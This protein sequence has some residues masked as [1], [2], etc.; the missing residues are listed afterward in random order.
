MQHVPSSSNAQRQRKVK[1]VT[2]SVTVPEGTESM[3]YGYVGF[4]WSSRGGSSG[5]TPKQPKPKSPTNLVKEVEELTRAARITQNPNTRK[6]LVHRVEKLLAELSDSSDD[7]YIVEAAATS[8]NKME[9]EENSQLANTIASAELKAQKAKAKIS[10]NSIKY[11]LPI[12]LE[13]DYITHH[14]RPVYQAKT[15]E[16]MASSSDQFYDA[17][18][19]AYDSSSISDAPN[20]YYTNSNIF[21]SEYPLVHCVS[22]D[23]K[24]SKGIARMVVQKYG[25]PSGVEQ[26][27]NPGDIFIQEATDR[28]IFHVVTKELFYQ[29]PTARTF[30]S[31]MLSLKQAL[32]NEGITHISMPCIGSGL[33]KMTW[34]DTLQIIKRVFYNSGITIAI[35][36]GNNSRQ[37]VQIAEKPK[38]IPNIHPRT[39]HHISERFTSTDAQGNKHTRVQSTYKHLGQR[40]PTSGGTTENIPALALEL[41]K[42]WQGIPKPP[43][44]LSILDKHYASLNCNDCSILYRCPKHSP[45]N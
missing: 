28:T 36:R 24:M 18:S 15:T 1:Q 32:R 11:D 31:G 17:Q 20:F 44:K 40:P 5:R 14:V 29:K 8:F 7:E 4:I 34:H 21:N 23:F 30:K 3:L 9:V 33:D 26:L 39:P 13:T 41:F 25:R 10:E 42:V 35:H 37:N 19:D 12:V 43:P 2:L 16:S 45:Y 38:L 6:L 27:K 22:G